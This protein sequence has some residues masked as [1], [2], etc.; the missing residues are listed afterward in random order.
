LTACAGGDATA[1]AELYQETSA[2]LFGLALRILRR[3]DWA[4]EALQDAYVK[5]WNHAA[6][7]SSQKG[8]AFGWMATIVRNRSL[9]LLRRGRWELPVGDETGRLERGGEAMDPLGEA[10]RGQEGEALQRCLGE[11]EAQPREAILLA[12]WKGLSHPELA[13][14]LQKPLGTIKSWVRRGLERLKGCLER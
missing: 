14:Q 1:L 7:F 8:S 5:I 11:L 12:F 6:D 4:E 9:D 10:I 3:R 13:E 2:N